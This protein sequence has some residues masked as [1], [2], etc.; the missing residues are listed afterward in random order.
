MLSRFFPG[1]ISAFCIS[2]QVW[3]GYGFSVPAAHADLII[4]G[5][6]NSDAT[7]FVLSCHLDDHLDD[8]IDNYEHDSEFAW[9][10]FFPDNVLRPNT[11]MMTGASYCAA[12][13]SSSDPDLIYPFGVWIAPNTKDTKF[14]RKP[15]VGRDSIL[16]S[17]T[18]NLVVT[19]N[20]VWTIGKSGHDFIC[21]DYI[22]NRDLTLEPCGFVRDDDYDGLRL[23]V[24]K[25]GQLLI[26]PVYSN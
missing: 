17:Q 24:K 5:T 14:V 19:K 3:L 9:D 2:L 25:T 8:D 15:V 11:Y 22:N 10:V 16:P 7:A 6:N 20:H 21:R 13:R 18:A 23:T 12:I 1:F 4:R 26:N